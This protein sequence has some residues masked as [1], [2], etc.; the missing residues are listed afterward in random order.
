MKVTDIF[1]K[2]PVLAICVNLIILITGIQSINK[3]T[4]RQYPQSDSAKITV[5]TTYVGANADLVRGFITT[6]LE[7]VIASADGIDYLES[8]SAQGVSTITA[9]LKLN[10]PVV[11]ALTQI[12]S[13]VNQVKNELPEGSEEPVIDMQNT[14]DKFASLFISFYSDELAANEITDYLIRVIQPKLSAVQGVQKADILGGRTFAMRV[15]MDPDKMASLNIRA[16]DVYTALKQNNYL[17]ALGNSKGNMVKVVLNANTDVQDVAGFENL[18]IKDEDGTLV[19]LKDIARVELGAEDYDTDIRFEGKSA[20]FIGIWPLPNANSLDVI[21]DVKKLLPEIERILPGSIKFRVNYDAT[22]YIRNAI[23]EVI[24]TLKETIVLVMIVI[25]L[26]IGSFRSVFVP[27]VVIPLSLVGAFGLILAMGFS[28]NLLTLLAIVLAV[29]L[30]VDDAIV[31]LENVERHVS[32]GKKPFDAAIIAAREL[33]APVITMTITLAAVYAPIGLQG[34]LTGTLFKEF[35]F[36]LAGTVLISGF[37]ALTLSPMMSS[38]LVSTKR[39]PLK[40]FVEGA[41]EL[42]RKVYEKLLLIS[43]NARSGVLIFAVFIMFLIFPLYKMS[44]SELA[45]SEDQ[46]AMFASIEASVNSTVEQTERYVKPIEDILRSFDE[47]E[48]FFNVVQP[49]SGFSVITLKPWK[50]RARH[51][52]ELKMIA[53]GQVAQVAGIRTNIMTPPALP[54]GSIF[55]I[56]FVITSTDEPIALLKEA[57]KIIGAAYASKKFMYIDAD[58]K[59]DYP[60]SKLMIDHEKIGTMGLNLSEIGR[61]VSIFLGGNY[62]N[63][64]N[65]QGRS[66]KVIPQVNRSNRLNPEQLNDLYIKGGKDNLIK[67]STVSTLQDSVEPRE[68]KKFQQLNSVKLQGLLPSGITLDEGLK[69][70]EEA[71]K[72]LPSSYQIDYAGQSRQLRTEGDS[73]TTTLILS[74]ILIYLV[75]ASQFESFR[76]PFIILFGSVPLALSAA[77]VFSFL[78]FTTMNIYSQVGLVTLV[79]LVSKNG[80]LIVEFAN[81]LRERGLSKLDAIKQSCITRLRPVLMTSVATVVGHLPLMFAKGPGAGSRNSIGMMLV[82]GMFIGTIFTLFVVPCIYTVVSK[83][84]WVKKDIEVKI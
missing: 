64:F 70:L 25:F 83:N 54:G 36:T 28:I 2:R 82:T 32:E 5:T 18:V 14:N 6:P 24:D 74:F 80:I 52:D 12:Q 50:E 55:P 17:S 7:R 49:S 42:V 41:F 39:G 47:A 29:G 22:D 69:V 72:E 30:V 81:V 9:N 48:V 33:A 43:L 38:K 66:Y 79:G 1:I 61:D 4:T 40:V 67:L 23:H 68:L 73:L 45:P 71:A 13:K 51:V 31:M 56:E 75:L 53:Q 57:Q 21:K 60:Q 59:Y 62:V 26:F 76:D 34:G 63:R 16:V 15:W 27:I 3:L 20:I 84:K 11:E 78:G 10:Y 8:S 37:I 46:G 58:L 35:A 77:L 19:R 44:K 65:M